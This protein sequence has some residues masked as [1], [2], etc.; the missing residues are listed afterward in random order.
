MSL[1]TKERIVELADQLYYEKGFG[2]TSFADIASEVGIS[3]GNFYHHFK[4]KDEILAAVIEKRMLKTEMMLNNWEKSGTSPADRIKCFINILIMNRM[5]IKQFG[6]PVGSL[7]TELAKLDHPALTDAN[8]V[9]TLF[10]TWLSKQFASLGYKKE[11]DSLAMHLLGRSQGIATM[12]SA[13]HSE[14]FLYQEVETLNQWL[15]S[16]TKNK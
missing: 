5:K 15:S 7:T 11:A 9:F 10:K 12:A 2:S 16:Y 6:C 4:T 14:E 1:T 3:R 8:Q 13:F